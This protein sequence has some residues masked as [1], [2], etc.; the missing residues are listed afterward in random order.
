MLMS[1]AALMFVLR[2]DY[3]TRQ[4]EDAVGVD[5]RT[6]S[7]RFRDRPVIYIVI[8]C[9]FIILIINRLYIGD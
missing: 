6:V 7:G 2:L 8:V 3:R 1:L 4:L 5:E 9:T